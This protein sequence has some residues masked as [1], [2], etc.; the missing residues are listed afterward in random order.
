MPA[1]LELR[2]YT[3]LPGRR[4]DLIDLFDREFIESQEALG[5][6]VV[7]QFRDLDDPDQFVWLRGFADMARRATGLGAFYGGPV[8]QAHR[9][10]ANATMEDSSN[11]LLLRPAVARHGFR[12]DDRPRPPLGAA[13]CPASIITAT[14]YRLHRPADAEFLG[15]F[16]E[17]LTPTLIDAGASLLAAY[18]TLDVENNFPAL[19]IRTGSPVFVWFARHGDVAAHHACRQRLDPPALRDHFAAPPVVLRLSPTARSRLR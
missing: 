7:G 9:A 15:L 14:I 13:T 2:R 18:Q 5:L 10:V 12:A 6:D 8:W 16:E 4:D 11:V 17:Q 3:L 1:I 19:P